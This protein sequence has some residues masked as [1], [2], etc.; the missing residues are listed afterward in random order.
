MREVILI[1]E[2]S[3]FSLWARTKMAWLMSGPII[4]VRIHITEEVFLPEGSHAMWPPRQQS[5]RRG[6]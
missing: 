1:M 5:S 2:P 4:A 6:S 3:S